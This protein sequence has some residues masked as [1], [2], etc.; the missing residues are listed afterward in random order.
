MAATS[1]AQP[2]VSSVS[3][4]PFG[5]RGP[6]AAVASAVGQVFRSSSQDQLPSQTR[7]H[8]LHPPYGPVTRV[9]HHQPI[10]HPNHP[11]PLPPPNPSMNYSNSQ[12]SFVDHPPSSSSSYHFQPLQPAQSPHIP[13]SV[14]PPPTNGS[15]SFISHQSIY[16]QGNHFH[17]RTNSRPVGV[18]QPAIG[19]YPPSNS[20]ISS[21]TGNNPYNSTTLPLSVNNSSNHQGSSLTVECTPSS[22]RSSSTDSS[23]D[24]GVISSSLP[25][26]GGTPGSSISSH[27][28]ATPHPPPSSSYGSNGR[29]MS[30]QPSSS[31]AMPL[32]QAHLPHQQ[33]SLNTP[34]SSSS[35]SGNLPPP[36]QPTGRRVRA[37]Y[38]CVGENPAELSF[39]PNAII[40]NGKLIL[41][42][43]ENVY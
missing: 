22:D 15:S 17:Q 29:S 1:A 31:A 38:N 18:Y 41:R 26:H 43:F 24:P 33:H 34:S 27:V 7:H 40:Y 20:L 28:Y 5:G 3:P 30:L 14:V 4:T 10:L 13:S 42:Y 12:Q 39:E 37:L 16:P 6:V 21:L 8:S 2:S 35:M 9:S 23:L 36:G 32:Q 19:G 25:S 11:P